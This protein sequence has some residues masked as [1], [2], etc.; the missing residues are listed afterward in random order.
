MREA[1]G[2]YSLFNLV[3]IFVLLFTGYISISINHSKAYNV[4]NEI[5]N[6]IKN[7]G[8]ICSSGTGVC[9]NFRDQITDYFKEAN[10]RNTNTCKDGFYGFDREGNSLGYEAEN[11]YF[12]VKGIKAN[13]SSELPNSLYYQVEVFY[14]LDLPIIKQFFRF[15]VMGETTNIY[16]PNECAYES[17]YNWCS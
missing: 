11:A 2:G 1:I 14:N 4:K 7:Q 9:K 12:C 6:I 5:V 8:G 16:A 3:I 10:Y 13:T 15:S 17:I